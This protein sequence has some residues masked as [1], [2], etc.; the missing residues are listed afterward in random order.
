MYLRRERV[1]TLLSVQGALVEQ[2]SIRRSTLKVLMS[3]E[4]PMAAS[5][6]RVGR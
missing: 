2:E 5:A 3:V 4:H 1:S 6:S